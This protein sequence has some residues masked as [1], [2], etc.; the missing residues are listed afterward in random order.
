MQAAE[1]Q[2]KDIIDNAMLGLT[3]AL[4]DIAHVSPG[5]VER[6]VEQRALDLNVD[7][8]E[9]RYLSGSQS[10]HAPSPSSSDGSS[11]DCT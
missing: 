9:N 10:Y 7:I 6:L 4:N 8:L 1:Q 11:F 3:H 2:R 5:E